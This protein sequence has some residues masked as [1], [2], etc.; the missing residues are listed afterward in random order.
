MDKL[1][2]LIKVSVDEHNYEQ[3]LRSSFFNHF[4]RKLEECE[5]HTDMDT[6]RQN[7]DI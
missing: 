3:C 6:I 4:P 5:S 1:T 2:I 7:T